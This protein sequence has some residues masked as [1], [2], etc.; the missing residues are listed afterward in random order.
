MF[1]LNADP[2]VIQFHDDVQCL[3]LA[4]VDEDCAFWVIIPIV[5][6]FKSEV[7]AFEDFIKERMPSLDSHLSSIQFSFAELVERWFLALCT[8][9]LMPHSSITIQHNVLETIFSNNVYLSVSTRS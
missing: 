7:L 5:V 6:L 3:L 2:F 4:Y 9:N 1:Y 8:A